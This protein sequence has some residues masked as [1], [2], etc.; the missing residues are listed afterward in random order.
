MKFLK[1]ESWH[2]VL[3]PYK[4]HGDWAHSYKTIGRKVSV[5][6]HACRQVYACKSNG[7][8]LDTKPT[9][10]TDSIC[11]YFGVYK[12]YVAGQFL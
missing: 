8:F 11:I 2:V 9:S 7:R 1:L 6:V 5:I 3:I 10:F 12:V 4:F